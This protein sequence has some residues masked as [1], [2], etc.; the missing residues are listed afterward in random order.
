M[1]LRMSLAYHLQSDNQTEVMNRIIKQYLRAFVHH[2]PSTWGKFLPWVEWS[3]NT[4]RNTSNG[5]SPFEVT[6]GKKPP[7]IPQ[8]I[9]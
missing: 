5:T 2:K 7:S 9:T 4:S 3:Y 8:Y 6:F 1:K